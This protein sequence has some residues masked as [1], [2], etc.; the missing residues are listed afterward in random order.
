MTRS[1]FWIK[2]KSTSAKKIR[3]WI[4]AVFIYHIFSDIYLTNSLSFSTLSLQE[5]LLHE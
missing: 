2:L 1:N 5:V 4:M 3:N